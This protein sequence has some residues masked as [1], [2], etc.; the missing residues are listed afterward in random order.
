MNATCCCQRFPS[1]LFFPGCCCCCRFHFAVHL[2]A[3]CLH[4]KTPQLESDEWKN[5]E[6]RLRP[7]A[8]PPPMLG[9][10]RWVVFDYGPLIKAWGF[11]ESTNQLWALP[12]RALTQLRRFR[13]EGSELS[14][15][16]KLSRVLLPKTWQTL[17]I[18]S[19]THSLSAAFGWRLKNKANLT[20]NLYDLLSL[21]SLFVAFTFKANCKPLWEE[22]YSVWTYNC[23]YEERNM[24]TPPKN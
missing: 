20:K 1:S 13:V 16:R 15:H 7:N 3:W 6:L 19:C 17:V 10:G 24:W 21:K 5:P 9:L 22:L 11:P 8:H 12:H 18:S 4:H 2:D 14:R 23:D